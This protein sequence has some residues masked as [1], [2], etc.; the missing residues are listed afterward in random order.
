[1][2]CTTERLNQEK[3]IL[4]IIRNSRNEIVDYAENFYDAEKRARKKKGGYEVRKGIVVYK[5]LLHRIVR[6]E[7]REMYY[8][9]Y[10][11]EPLRISTHS[12]LEDAQ[13]AVEKS[14]ESHITFLLYYLFR[15]QSLLLA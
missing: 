8:V 7:E 15:N 3:Q 4:Y 13:R 1:M 10:K 9:L 2:D 11:D 12:T 6:D 14:I 5:S